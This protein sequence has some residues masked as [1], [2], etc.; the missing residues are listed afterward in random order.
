MQDLLSCFYLNNKKYLTYWRITLNM[1]NTL[2][3]MDYM[4]VMRPYKTIH[5]VDF[6]HYSYCIIA[7]PTYMLYICMTSM[8]LILILYYYSIIQCLF[9][10]PIPI[11]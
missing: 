6:V 10:W 11:G 2:M 4:A 8:Y 3:S 5:Q 9:A 1:S 7:V